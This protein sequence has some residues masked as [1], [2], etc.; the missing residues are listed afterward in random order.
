MR[1]LL[2]ECGRGALHVGI[3]GRLEYANVR[4]NV[5][6]FQTGEELRPLPFV[7]SPHPNAPMLV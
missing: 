5:H 2:R 7:H 6:T 1:P 4:T 3:W